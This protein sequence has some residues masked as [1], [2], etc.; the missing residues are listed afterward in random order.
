M[1]E[2]ATCTATNSDYATCGLKRESCR[3]EK[4]HP[5]FPITLAYRK[6]KNYIA[7]TTEETEIWKQALLFVPTL[8]P[9]FWRYI[10]SNSRFIEDEVWDWK[11]ELWDVSPFFGLVRLSLTSFYYPQTTKIFD[12]LQEIVFSK[13]SKSTSFYDFRQCEVSKRL[14][15]VL[16]LGLLSGPARYIR[17]LFFSQDRPFSLRLFSNLFSLKPLNF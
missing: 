9:N 8:Y 1:P 5:H 17:I 14:F 2:V 6:C 7:F 4:K 13:N 12:I 16:K 15:L 11:E 3:A 10:G